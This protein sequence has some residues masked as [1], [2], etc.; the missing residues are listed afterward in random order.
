MLDPADPPRGAI[1]GACHATGETAHQ[2]SQILEGTGAPL[3][4]VMAASC[5]RPAYTVCQMMVNGVFDRFPDLRI[6][7]AETGGGW[8][9]YFLEQSDQV[10]HNFGPGKGV[11]LQMQPSEYFKKHVM[12]GFQVDHTAIQLRHVIGVKNLSWRNDFPHSAGYWPHSRDVIEDHFGAV[13]DDE[14]QRMVADNVA[15]FYLM[16]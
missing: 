1:L 4:T 3:H 8:V 16:A 14:K 10:Y 12:V 9:P 2:R 13:P 11:K 7:F 6:H 15:E 5:P